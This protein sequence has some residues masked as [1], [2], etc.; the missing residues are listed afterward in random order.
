MANVAETRKSLIEKKQVKKN[1]VVKELNIESRKTVDFPNYGS[2]S[3][4]VK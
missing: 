4:T 1:F 2:Q 3:L